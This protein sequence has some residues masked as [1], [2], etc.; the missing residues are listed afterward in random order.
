M[1][2]STVSSKSSRHSAPG[3]AIRPPITSDAAFHPDEVE[4]TARAYGTHATLFPDM[5]HGMMLEPGWHGVAEA[6]RKWLHER[7]L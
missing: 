4:A 6:M 3:P 7:G 2:S 5:A 1:R